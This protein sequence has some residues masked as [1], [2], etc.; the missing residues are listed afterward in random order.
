IG[1]WEDANTQT[2]VDMVGQNHRGGV[3]VMGYN[4]S[5]N[6][7][8]E[9]GTDMTEQISAARAQGQPVPSGVDQ[10]GGPVSHLATAALPCRPLMALAATNDSDLVTE[11][12]TVQAANLTDLGFSIDVAPDADVTTGPDDVTIN[13]RSAGTDHKD[14]AEVV[15]D[16]VD[17]Y[18]AGGVA[19]SAKHFPGHGRLGVDSHESLPVSKKSI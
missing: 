3:I 12:T 13:V 18:R 6:P 4:R 2:A 11:A 17:G 9:Q 14:A 15:A 5:E 1:T 7:T 16:A 10:D 8:T 19:S